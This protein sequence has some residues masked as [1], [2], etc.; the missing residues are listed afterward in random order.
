MTTGITWR[1]EGAAD[2]AAHYGGRALTLA[3]Y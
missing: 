2:W 1:G 3:H